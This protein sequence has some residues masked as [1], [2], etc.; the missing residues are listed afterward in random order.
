MNLF[1]FTW[2]QYGRA[3][4]ACSLI[5]MALFVFVQFSLRS[6]WLKDNWTFL[7]DK[8]D[9]SSSTLISHKIPYTYQA[10]G[11]AFIVKNT[12]RPDVFEPAALLL[13]GNYQKDSLKEALRKAAVVISGKVLST[14]IPDTTIRHTIS[15][16]DPLI[17][18]A[19]I[20][21]KQVLKGKKVKGTI[22]VYY[23][24]SD[25]VQW[26]KSPKPFVG[27][28]AIFLLHSNN[29]SKQVNPKVY[30]LLSYLDV[31]EL[32]KKSRIQKLL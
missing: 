30:A 15:E 10:T 27:Q 28:V 11:R 8:F 14:N 4:L 29:F 12:E 16:H 24:S 32:E 3:I 22:A 25:D 7:S 20:E 19:V 9:K 1:S 6:G 18:K 23:A 31:Q 5:P 2:H 13:T 21:V 26:Y 17:R